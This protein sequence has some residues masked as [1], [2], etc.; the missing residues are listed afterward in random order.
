MPQKNTLAGLDVSGPDPLYKQVEQRI[1][2][3]L[4]DGEW[5]PGEQLPTESQLADRFGVAVFTIRAGIG[6]LA[7]SNILV[8][9]QGKGTFVA[10]HSRLRQRYQ[11][12][13]IHDA[14]GRQILPG[15]ELLSF[16]K[17]TATAAEAARL[18]FPPGAK[19]PVIRLAMI[20]VDEG[21]T[22]ATLDIVLPA[23]LFGG[24]TAAAV[25]SAQENLYAAYQ[26]EC[27]VNVIRVEEHIH[28]ALAGA[29]EAKTLKIRTGSPVLRVER[30]AYTYRGLPVEFRTRVF[31][32]TQY[33]YRTVEGGI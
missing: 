4:A 12:S 14:A 27:G 21:K 19:T 15:R 32:A 17:G 18:G 6:E 25:R 10:R 22:V 29:A 20:S 31:D 13:H 30:M 5:K 8:R 23:R 28:A 2:Q 16:T 9:K 26:D 33:H 3:C 7:A 24:L 1:L 11:F